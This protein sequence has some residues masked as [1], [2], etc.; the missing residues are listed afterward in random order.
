MESEIHLGSIAGLRLTAQ[1]SFFTHRLIFLIAL[2]IIG[3][4]ALGLS[5]A[6]AVLGAF[7]AVV[8]DAIAVL[9][10]QLGHSWVAQKVGFPMIGIS[11]W[12]L[13]AT[14]IY[15]ADEPELP[16]KLHIRR[17]LGGPPLNF[18]VGLTTGLPA[19]WFLPQEGPIRLL[20]IFWIVDNCVVR[21][22]M[23]FGPFPWTDGPTIR[24]WAKRT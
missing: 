14:C 12:S 7:I 10:H 23:A 24:Y 19:L 6:I 22:I 4:F 21:S 15:P 13:F 5:L 17:A 16:P 8:L 20:V 9:I 1:R 3:R 11:F 18:L 2:A